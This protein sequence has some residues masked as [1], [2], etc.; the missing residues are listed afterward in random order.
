MNAKI[1]QARPS[2]VAAMHRVRLSV[3]ENRLTSVALSERDYVIAIEDTG[4]GWVVELQGR[5]VSFAVGNSVNGSI[6]ALFVE[7]GHEGKGYGRRLH[8]IMI[9]WL[10]EQGHHHLW[11]TTEPGTR[12]ERFYLQAGWERAAAAAG[13]EIRFELKRPISGAQS[14][15]EDCRT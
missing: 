7:P 1:R 11:L 3:R 2:D 10:W 4:R 15:R 5:I 9:R 14:T 6:W 13:G 8:D 12:A